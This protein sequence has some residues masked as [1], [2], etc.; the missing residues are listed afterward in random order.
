MYWRDKRL[1]FMPKSGGG[2]CLVIWASCQ[3]LMPAQ[4]EAV[5]GGAMM[6]QPHE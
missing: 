4:A 6:T 5:I 1:G 3:S 2:I